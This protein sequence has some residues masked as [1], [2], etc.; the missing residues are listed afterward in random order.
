MPDLD[1]QRRK[2]EELKRKI[3]EQKKKEVAEACIFSCYR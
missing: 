3:L 2:V 1:E